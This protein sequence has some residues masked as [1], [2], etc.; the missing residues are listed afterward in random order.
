MVTLPAFRIRC[1]TGVCDVDLAQLLLC[2]CQPKMK[3]L[4]E[5]GIGV[6]PN[7][8]VDLI[9]LGIEA[10]ELNVAAVEVG[11]DLHDDLS[12]LA[13]NYANYVEG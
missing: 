13:A 5:I 3:P 11:R 9:C 6:F 8:K 1:F 2:T 10:H 4:N 12:N 7:A